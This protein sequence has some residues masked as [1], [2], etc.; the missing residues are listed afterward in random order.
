MEP[1]NQL[2]GCFQVFHLMRAPLTPHFSWNKNEF[3]LHPSFRWLP[4]FL[5]SLRG[6]PFHVVTPC[7]N[8]FLLF[9]YLFH[10]VSHLLRLLSLS[11]LHQT[12]W[13]NVE[14][15][16]LFHD[17]SKV[18][19]T[20]DGSLKK[21]PKESEVRQELAI[22]QMA[23]NCLLVHI[24]PPGH[25]GLLAIS[26]RGASPW[27]TPASDLFPHSWPQSFPIPHSSISSLTSSF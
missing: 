13:P 2:W 18:W 5:R 19:R 23:G 20:Q 24:G 6:F 4:T 1:E 7:P 10:L 22:Q 26:A 25:G 27:L 16:I 17:F 15:W 8:I 3:I 12:K 21:F 9:N 14:T 11:T